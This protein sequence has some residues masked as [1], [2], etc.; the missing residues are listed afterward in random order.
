MTSGRTSANLLKNFTLPA[1]SAF[2]IPTATQWLGAQKFVVGYTTRK[3]GQFDAESSQTASITFSGE[4]LHTETNALV[5]SQ[6]TLIGGHEDKHL[7]LFDMRTCKL[8]SVTCVKA[9]VGH[10]EAVSCLSAGRESQVVSGSH[11]GSLRF[12]DMRT[13]QCYFEVSVRCKQAH[14]RQY[15]EAVTA[16]SHC[17]SGVVSGGADSLVRLF[18]CIDE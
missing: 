3:I 5:V 15:V 16:V 12:W 10:T 4:G 2:H 8:Y 17:P 7:R 1:P 9:I 14:R 13:F 18:A 11:D 6:D